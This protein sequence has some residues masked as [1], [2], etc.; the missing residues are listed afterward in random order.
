MERIFTGARGT[1]LHDALTK[2]GEQRF[3]CPPAL[4][5][6]Q[7]RY[8]FQLA[9]NETGLNRKRRKRRTSRWRRVCVTASGTEVRGEPGGGEACC[10]W[11]A[12]RRFSTLLVCSTLNHCG[13]ACDV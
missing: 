11:L 7:C 12:R 5:A 6:T 8:G 1:N 3:A 4:E 10:G 13:N 2:D 9:E